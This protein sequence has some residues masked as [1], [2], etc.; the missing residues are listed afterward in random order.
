MNV[1]LKP[2]RDTSAN[3]QGLNPIL[4]DR[5]WG[6]E[7]D[8][9]KEKFGNG[10]SPWNELPYAPGGSPAPAT[11]PFTTEIPFTRPVT[12]IEQAAVSDAMNFTPLVDDALPGCGAILRL[13]ADDVHTP[14]FSGFKKSNA[15]QDWVGTIDTINVVVFLY[16]GVDFWYTLY[17]MAAMSPGETPTVLAAPAIAATPVS[18]TQIS[19][20]VGTVSNASSYDVQQSADGSAWETIGT[21]AGTYS[22]SGLAPATQYFFRAKAIGDN[23]NTLSSGYA[24]ASAVTEATSPAYDPDAQTY[25]SAVAAAGGTLSE[26]KKTSFNSAVIAAKAAGVWEKLIGLYPYG[27]GNAAAHAINAKT[28]GTF[29]LTWIGG[30]VHDE[31]G[32]DPNGSTGD[33]NTGFIPAENTGIFDIAESHLAVVLTEDFAASNVKDMGVE[34]NSARWGLISR[35]SENRIGFCAGHASYAYTSANTNTSSIG[36]YILTRSTLSNYIRL[37]KDGVAM[38]SSINVASEPTSSFP[39]PLRVCTAQAD[40]PLSSIHSPRRQ[41]LA[42]FG[43]PLSETEATA[44]SNIIANLR[45]AWGR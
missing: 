3:W 19:L 24:T 4:E 37:Y 34:G 25:F 30:I 39:H 42:H 23:V 32:I 15:S 5:E 45:T 7:A 20:V 17:Q 12:V 11:I 10:T 2:R 16:D 31:D 33:G 26:N 44:L 18:D 29:D 28:P 1:I 21:T 41:A 14:T 43:G 9:G 36:Y 40:T 27:G 6:I 13:Q 22:R 38:Y 35:N 8:T